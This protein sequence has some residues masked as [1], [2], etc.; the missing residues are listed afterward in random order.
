MTMVTTMADQDSDYKWWRGSLTEAE[1][2]TLETL[3]K[4]F[5]GLLSEPPSEVVFMVT[6]AEYKA[7]QDWTGR[8]RID[9]E[10]WC[11]WKARSV[12]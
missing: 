9:A 1:P 2:L 8:E 5:D 12:E 6:A 11:C 4:A 7:V 3:K 10:D